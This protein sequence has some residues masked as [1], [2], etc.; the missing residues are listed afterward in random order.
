M[1]IARLPESAYNNRHPAPED[2]F[3]VVEVAKTSLKK[4]LELKAY[5]YAAAQIPEY[6]V[7]DL[8]AKQ[9]IV[10]REPLDGKYTTEQIIVQGT[11]TPLAFLEI[12]VSVEKLLS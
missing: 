11:I 12:Q 2:I 5:I 8:S 9:I 6:W 1:R 7:L 10:F 3:W 4:D